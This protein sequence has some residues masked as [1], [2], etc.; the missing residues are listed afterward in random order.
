[1]LEEAGVDILLHA[2]VAEPLRGRE[3]AVTGA[4]LLTKQGLID[5]PA[6]VVIDATG[7]GDVAFAAGAEFE[8]GTRGRPRLVGRRTGSA[9]DHHV[10]HFRG[11][12]CRINGHSRR[13]RVAIGLPMVR[14]W[15]Q[16]C[17]DANA[18]GEA[19]EE[20]RESA[21][22]FFASRRPTGDQRD[23][24]QL[25]GRHEGPGS[26]Q[27]RVGGAGGRWSRFSSFYERMRRGSRMPTCRGCLP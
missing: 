23:A 9:D 3:V 12:P 18:K 1:M 7:D 22:L 25:R 19:A 2:A 11:Q 20:R 13:A 4:R 21:D 17:F 15:D 16:L 14:S 5:V 27:G 10:P 6:R 26:D 8:Q 24:G